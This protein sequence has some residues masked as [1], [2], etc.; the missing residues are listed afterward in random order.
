M[1]SIPIAYSEIAETPV[2]AEPGIFRSH[3]PI[4]HK[5]IKLIHFYPAILFLI[6]PFLGA[7]NCGNDIVP[8]HC[9]AVLGFFLFL[10]VGCMP[11]IV[12]G[13]M[14]FELAK[15]SFGVFSLT[16]F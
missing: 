13:K 12:G 2:W 8:I 9:E 15:P 5:L 10:N 7:L 14:Q 3:S 16:D 11:L 6:S 1:A 4:T